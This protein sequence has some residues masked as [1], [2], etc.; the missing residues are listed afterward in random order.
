[1]IYGYVPPED[2]LLRR[3][4]RRKLLNFNANKAAHRIR[5]IKAALNDII[6]EAGLREISWIEIVER[7]DMALYAIVLATNF[8]DIKASEEQIQ[9]LKDIFITYGF[10]PCTLHVGTLSHA[11]HVEYLIIVL[12]FVSA[13]ISYVISI[14]PSTTSHLNVHY[15]HLSRRPN[16]KGLSKGGPNY[17]LTLIPIRIKVKSGKA[18]E[19][20]GKGRRTDWCVE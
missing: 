12:M 15:I 9:R 8:D 1:M 19:P 6:N 3:C 16:H 7:D 4:K 20:K 2:W 5:E 10:F 18:M 17:P 13:S 11:S 14:T